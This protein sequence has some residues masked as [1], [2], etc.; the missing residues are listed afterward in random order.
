MPSQSGVAGSQQYVFLIGA[1][2]C[3]TTAL[4]DMLAQHPDVNVSNPKEPD[5]FARPDYSGHFDLYDACFDRTRPF[6]YR[7]DASVGY[8]ADWQGVS[9]AIAE[10]ISAFCPSAKLI[11]VVRDPIER[12]RSA[13]WHAVRAGYENLSFWDSI[14]N[15]GIDHITA[16]RYS[17]RIDEYLSSFPPSQLLLLTFQELRTE[18]QRVLQ[19]VLDFLELPPFQNFT[20]HQ[21]TNRTYQLSVLGKLVHRAL[22]KHRITAAVKFAKATLPKRIVDRLYDA[23]A[24]PIPEMTDREADYLAML[25]EFEAAE[26]Q[27]RYGINL[28]TSKWWRGR[29]SITDKA[30]VVLP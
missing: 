25:F 17:E 12:T 14:Q 16:S 5:F 23:Y 29:Q 24:K 15:L 30:Q 13:Y 1:A 10:R 20:L 2:K 6:R 11:Y 3:G 27:R 4:A 28:R 7:L 21:E 22:P 26:M 18:P 19:R 9:K 8:T